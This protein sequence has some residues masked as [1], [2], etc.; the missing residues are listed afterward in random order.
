MGRGLPCGSQVYAP[1]A[2]PGSFVAHFLCCQ[3]TELSLKA[4]LSLRGYE[5]RSLWGKALGHN[6]SKLFEEAVT[7]N[8]AEYVDIMAGDAALLESVTAWYDSPNKRFQ[9]VDLGDLLRGFGSAPPYPDLE[10]FATRMQSDKLRE[11]VKNA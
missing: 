11:A 1:T 2:R 6:L 5:R 4:L 8:L 3:S 9:Y 7:Q 10:E